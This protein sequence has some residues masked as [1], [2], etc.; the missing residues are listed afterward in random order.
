LKLHGLIT[1]RRD[2]KEVYYKL[3]ETDLADL[4]HQMIDSYFNMVCPSKRHYHE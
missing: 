2:G 3:A 4:I 1:S